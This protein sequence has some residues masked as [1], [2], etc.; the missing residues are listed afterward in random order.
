M[1]AVVGDVMPSPPCSNTGG[2]PCTEPTGTL[3]HIFSGLCCPA[4][5]LVKVL[6]HIMLRIRKRGLSPPPLTSFFLVKTRSRLQPDHQR[7]NHQ[8]V[9]RYDVAVY[10]GKRCL[11][12]LVS[13]RQTT[14]DKSDD[15]PAQKVLCPYS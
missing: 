4:A 2:I 8:A 5:Y 12:T 10:V 11:V 13:H 15:L 3:D 7:D 9:P 6:R 1:I 14:T